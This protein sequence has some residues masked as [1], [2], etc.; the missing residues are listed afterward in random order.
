MANI[1]VKKLVIELLRGQKSSTGTYGFADLGLNTDSIIAEVYGGSEYTDAERTF[2]QQF[3]A[4]RHMPK[5]VRGEYVRSLRELPC[6]CV[7]KQVTGE[8]GVPM[9]R[10]LGVD[11]SA[12]GPFQVGLKKGSYHK[13]TLK[14]EVRAAGG[15][16]PGIRDFI[17]HGLEWLIL[18]AM[19]YL[20][21]Q[22]VLVP[23]WRDGRDGSL[24]GEQDTHIIHMAEGYLHYQVQRTYTQIAN[25]GAG[26]KVNVQDNKGGVV[27]QELS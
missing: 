9:G 7:V 11:T 12:G 15:G 20:H 5:F 4:D 21:Q 2:I 25:R 13:K 6:V 22:G 27:P 19:P 16:S 23:V 3:F 8:Q 26:V 17:H 10:H 14:L 24:E 18:Q 1:D